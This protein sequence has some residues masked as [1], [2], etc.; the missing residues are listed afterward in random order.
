MPLR[1]SSLTFLGLLS[2]QPDLHFVFFLTVVG[3]HPFSCASW[4]LHPPLGQ[5]FPSFSTAPSRRLLS[6]R[7]SPSFFLFPLDAMLA[8]H[9]LEILK[10]CTPPSKPGSAALRAERGDS[11]PGGEQGPQHGLH[12]RP[13]LR[14]NVMHM[15]VPW[16]LAQAA[17]KRLARRPAA[18][19]ARLGLGRL[20]LFTSAEE[21]KKEMRTNKQWA[22]IMDCSYTLSQ[23]VAVH[24]ALSCTCYAPFLYF[25]YYPCCLRLPAVPRA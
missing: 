12:P 15:Q 1:P 24:C 11:P 25:L 16:M 22:F 18:S 5:L 6:S 9:A 20:L 10:V 13:S 3:S 17:E 4:P 8:L 19:P 23:P 14:R 7:L 21:K 2:S